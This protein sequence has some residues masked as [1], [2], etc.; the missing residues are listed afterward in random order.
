MKTGWLTGL[1][2]WIRNFYRH[3]PR[4]GPSS[5]ET[6]VSIQETLSVEQTSSNGSSSTTAKQAKE[7]MIALYEGKPF[8][9]LKTDLEEVKGYLDRM[10]PVT[11]KRRG[12]SKSQE[13]LMFATERAVS[14]L[15]SAGSGKSTLLILRLLFMRHQLNIDYDHI[16]IFTF[17]HR[18]RQDLIR[19]LVEESARWPYSVDEKLAE[20]LVRTFHSKALMVA[21]GAMHPN[22]RIF[23]FLGKKEVG[24]QEDAERQMDA[25]KMGDEREPGLTAEE[26]AANEMMAPLEGELTPAQNRFVDEA[27]RICFAKKGKFREAIRH[28]LIS[29]IKPEQRLNPND[30]R[31][32]KAKDDLRSLTKL[33]ILYFE[34]VEEDWRA[35]RRWPIAGVMET[36]AAGQR[37]ELEACGTRLLVNGFVES[38][39]LYVVLGTRGAI[40]NETLK[41]RAMDKGRTL[42]GLERSK[43]R[44]L[45]GFNDKPIVYLRDA[46]QLQMFAAAMTQQVGGASSGAPKFSLIP[47]DNYIALPI[48]VALFHSGTF[49]EHL[50]L[51]PRRIANADGLVRGSVEH[52]F[53]AATALFFEEL[54]RLFDVRNVISFNRLFQR[55]ATEDH[56]RA[57]I[58]GGSVL[59]MKHLLIDEFQ[60]ISPATVRFV[61][62]MHERLQITSDGI[63]HPSVMC[64]GDDWQSIYGWR[65]SSP[66]MLFQF[67][68]YFQG[69]R[70]TAYRLRENYRSS[71]NVIKAA[72]AALGRLTDKF[73]D[74]EGGIAKGRWRD[75]P[76]PV[77]L[78]PDFETDEAV[79]LVRSILQILPEG[80]R[81]FVLTRSSR[82]S[83]FSAIEKA[84]SV[85]PKN[86]F[87]ATTFHQSKGLEAEYVI[88]IGDTRYTYTNVLRNALYRMAHLG[89]PGSSA[90]Y[91]DAQRNEAHRLAYVAITRAM[92]VCIWL[93]E[94]QDKG[95][96]A[97]LPEDGPASQHMT[98]SAAWEMIQ[99]TVA[100]AKAEA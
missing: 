5:A 47:P 72:E 14:V 25:E 87:T 67:S 91:D 38:L 17:T 9:F 64:V 44:V 29:S 27:Y 97:L 7:P 10:D 34:R 81:L 43:I 2:S 3:A 75:L 73:P 92:K 69:A 90:P 6:H 53:A 60:D 16:S 49:A 22:T 85:E 13:Q 40:R 78:V 1:G 11:G 18:S 66:Q 68:Q 41:L 24:D 54:Y 62:A 70:K 33:D 57:R 26:V 21:R 30:E 93:C 12:L 4:K 79:Q 94:P 80:E 76:Y 15:S 45:L 37:F 77:A 89:A 71:E 28:L 52:S 8:T 51:D 98:I 32:Q 74:K 58:A 31:V 63:D 86:R 35:Q 84:F 83:H 100:L 23:E 42:I 50:A 61:V 20:S 96:F 55:L 82:N 56:E 19:K 59:S 48:E 99:R 95:T 65:G 88:L 39:N 36:D 46:Q